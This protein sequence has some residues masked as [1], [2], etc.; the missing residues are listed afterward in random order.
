MF[1]LLL[2]NFQ[3]ISALKRPK[4]GSNRKL[5]YCTSDSQC[6]HYGMV[7]C[8][9][10]KGLCSNT[11]RPIPPPK[12]WTCQTASQCQEYVEQLN[13]PEGVIMDNLFC[14]NGI[15]QTRLVHPFYQRESEEGCGCKSDFE[16]NKG[17]FPLGVIVTKKF[18]CRKG[19]C[20]VDGKQIELDH[21]NRNSECNYGAF[22]ARVTIDNGFYCDRSQWVCKVKGEDITKNKCG[23]YD[24]GSEMESDTS[25]ESLSHEYDDSVKTICNTADDCNRGLF[26]EGVFVTSKFQ[27]IEGFCE[28]ED[29]LENCKKD[30][31]C[32]GYNPYRRGGMATICFEGT[33]AMKQ[34]AG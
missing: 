23:L 26:P 15:C 5:V 18:K 2:I 27:C 29:K 7:W 19:M 20:L 21:C 13:L 32:P 3:S 4:T 8:D 31:D 1:L 12:P 30:E 10:D 22:P 17:I 11:T 34:I 25:P 24:G 6:E 28:P 16:C 14:I 33:C 9:K